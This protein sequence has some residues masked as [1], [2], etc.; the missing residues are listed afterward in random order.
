M[1]E[2]YE[3]FMWFPG[4][5]A[6]RR[7]ITMRSP[8][9]PALSP[10]KAPGV[11]LRTVNPTGERCGSG[12]DAPL[13]T[14]ESRTRKRLQYRLGEQPTLRL[15]CRRVIRQGRGQALWFGKVRISGKIGPRQTRTQRQVS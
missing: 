6:I 15:Y 3:D 7:H 2:S 13:A 9:L 8:R 10:P 14:P 11:I 1:P 5:A 4:S 12:G